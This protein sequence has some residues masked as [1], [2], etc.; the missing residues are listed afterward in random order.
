MP[1]LERSAVSEPQVSANATSVE[2]AAAGARLEHWQE[3]RTAHRRSTTVHD[4]R[5][6][7]ILHQATK[8][9][10]AD[11]S[12]PDGGATHRVQSLTSFAGAEA[13]TTSDSTL[14]KIR[15]PA[16]AAL[17]AAATGL[18]QRRFGRL[19]R[20]GLVVFLLV[21]ASLAAVVLSLH[22]RASKLPPIEGNQTTSAAYATALVQRY[23]DNVALRLTLVRLLIDQG[24]LAAALAALPPIE[25]FKDEEMRR[26]YLLLRIEVLQ[27]AVSAAPGDEDLVRQLDLALV[28]ALDL[29]WTSGRM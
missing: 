1:A 15:G 2:D 25:Q 24:E 13:P 23:P 3:R 11:A 6:G 22:T 21:A 9:E 20:R 28:Q 14:E 17:A 7:S 16:L 19:A 27:K 8:T 4:R 5:R 12:D 18:G 10:S 29:Q 26:E